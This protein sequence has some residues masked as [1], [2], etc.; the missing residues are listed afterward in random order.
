MAGRHRRPGAG[1]PV[2]AA[3]VLGLA[4]ASALSFRLLSG[5]G[6]RRPP[7]PA[8]G[9]TSPPAAPSGPATPS[10]RGSSPAP[11]LAKRGPLVIQGTGDVN[12]D[13]TY[14]PNL[15]RY[16]YGYAWSGL[17]G[18]F[19]RDD[20]TVVNLECAVS[21]L[22][23]P[24]PKAFTFRG[25]PAALPAM[26]GAGVEVANL[27]NNHAYDFGP[28]ALLDARRNLLAAGI[29]PVGAGRDDREALSPALFRIRG[30][31]VAVLGFDEVVDP[32]PEAVARP[33]HPG[34]AAGHDEEAMVRAVRAAARRADLVVVAIHWGVELD[35]RPRAAQVALAHR[36]IDAGA[37]VIF[38]H[39][40]HRLQPM[41]VFR[42]R[43]IFYSLGNFVWP[44]HSLAGATTA[45]AEVR[46]GPN[47]R[48]RGRLIPAFIVSAGHPVLRG[49]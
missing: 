34:T 1:H 30:W 32:Y 42:G 3:A 31:T 28:R 4:L 2:L 27:A 47:G 15:R 26:R 12:L 49:S 38:G 18:L 11:S 44:N 10:G 13:P 6:P 9:S 14:I 25:D 17:G 45:V 29:A 5:P 48:I 39:H 33:G 20:L 46:V 7:P 40:S 35:T 36:L 23:S 43:P 41:G 22:G 24:L 16:G 19:R 8:T 37:D 21:R